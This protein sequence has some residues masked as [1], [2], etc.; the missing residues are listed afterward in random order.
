MNTQ[1]K[2]F[3]ITPS[4]PLEILRLSIQQQQGEAKPAISISSL[5]AIQLQ[6][7]S[8]ITGTS[9]DPAVITRIEYLTLNGIFHNDELSGVGIPQTED[10][11]W[12]IQLNF[13]AGVN[14]RRASLIIPK[15]RYP[16]HQARN[17]YFL[18]KIIDRLTEDQY[19]LQLEREQIISILEE[20]FTEM[21]GKDF[22]LGQ[23]GDN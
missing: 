22:I 7:F 15:K 16:D 12:I 20:V 6:A 3:G 8:S 11:L 5:K 21:T 18:Q 13:I 23:K 2:I 14:N 17:N 19:P 10:D 4:E 1:Y 9:A